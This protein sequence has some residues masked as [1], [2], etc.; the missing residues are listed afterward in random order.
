MTMLKAKLDFVAPDSLLEG[1]WEEIKLKV[2]LF[3][4]SKE[5]GRGRVIFNI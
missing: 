4:D 1:C 2:L 5:G 3:C